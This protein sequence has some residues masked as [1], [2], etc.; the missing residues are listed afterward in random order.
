MAEFRT[1]TNDIES[2]SN[3]GYFISIHPY[4]L[5]EQKFIEKTIHVEVKDQE[6]NPIYI[7]DLRT[8]MNGIVGFWLESG[9][10]GVL[11]ISYLDLKGKMDLDIEYVD[12]PCIGD[13]DS[14]LME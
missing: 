3:M 7:E 9:F 11:S 6:G 5:S 14:V 12:Y 1:I 10:K 13:V 8:D 2:Y 4:S